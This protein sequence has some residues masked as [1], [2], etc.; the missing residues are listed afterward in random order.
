MSC[1]CSVYIFIFLAPSSREKCCGSAYD[2]CCLF[3]TTGGVG[4]RPL[5]R[6]RFLGS[7]A[8]RYVGHSSRARQ[9]GRARIRRTLSWYPKGLSLKLLSCKGTLNQA[10]N[11]K[12]TGTQTHDRVIFVS[13]PSTSQLWNPGDFDLWTVQYREH[14]ITY[15]FV[16]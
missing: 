9:S 3:G 2:N 1:A 10:S 13:S 11:V 12:G 15:K 16:L 14:S 7:L 5:Y 6:R 4:F 8:T